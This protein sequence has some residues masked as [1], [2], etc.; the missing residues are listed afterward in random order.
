MQKDVIV[1]S[2]RKNTLKSTL[3]GFLPF[4]IFTVFFIIGIIL[5][6]KDK[7]T[8]EYVFMIISAVLDG[9]SLFILIFFFFHYIYAKRKCDK[10][11]ITFKGN[12]S[13]FV[14]TNCNVKDDIEINK[15][16]VIEVKI[17]EL[18]KAYLR[19]KN[20]LKNESIFIGYAIK[21]NEDLINNEL[22]KYKSLCS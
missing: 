2:K 3:I 7:Y 11:L 14:L 13:T 4:C 6:M 15:S 8:W 21:K 5:Y 19:Y 16:D 20:N 17:D 18:G 10:P 9:L 22:Q 1:L 12:D